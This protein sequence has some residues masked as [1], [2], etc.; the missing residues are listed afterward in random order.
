MG[1]LLSE[2]SNGVRKVLVLLGQEINLVSESIYLSNQ[3][4]DLGIKLRVFSL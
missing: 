1:E 3:L 4:G 2:L